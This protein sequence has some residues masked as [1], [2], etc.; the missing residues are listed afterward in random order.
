MR[1]SLWLL[2]LAPLIFSGCNRDQPQASSPAQ[3]IAP[4]AAPRDVIL[5]LGDSLTAGYG[6]TQ[7]E[8]YPVLLAARWEKEGVPFKA[9]NAG[10]SGATTAGL[11]ESLDWSLAPDVHTVLLAVGA[12]D[13]LRGLSLMQSRK[14]ISAI[15]EEARRR[16]IRVV[17]AGMK[18]PPNYGEA[19][20]RDFQSMYAELAQSHG[21]KRLPFLL[22]GVAGDPR[23]NIEDG[24]HPNAAGH[25]LIAERVDRFFKKEGILK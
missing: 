25:R 1:L 18:I 19:Y 5:F 24:I 6:V 21:L 15:I 20:I 14:N 16:G 23:Y 17:L 22:E 7:E 10:V 11:L 2:C 4:A 3:A 8:A 9:R 13:G 12:N